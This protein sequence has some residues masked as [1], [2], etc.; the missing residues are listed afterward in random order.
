MREKHVK[1]RQEFLDSC[2]E[3]NCCGSLDMHDFAKSRG[4]V[5]A[6]RRRHWVCT[7]SASQQGYYEAHLL[8]CVPASDYKGPPHRYFEDRGD[9]GYGNPD[10]FYL[11]GQFVCRGQVWVMTDLEVT[12]HPFTCE[13]RK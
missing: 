12:L 11:G 1:V 4:K 10:L 13:R 6:W 7:G 8:E 3:Q 5:I 2:A 9:D